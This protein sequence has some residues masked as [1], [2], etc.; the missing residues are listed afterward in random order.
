[1]TVSQQPP[2]R[3]HND[4]DKVWNEPE[5]KQ[6][7]DFNQTP[8]YINLPNLTKESPKRESSEDLPRSPSTDPGSPNM[9]FDDD[10]RN[11]L[12][13][14]STSSLPKGSPSISLKSL[15]PKALKKNNKT[16]QQEFQSNEA[17]L[18]HRRSLQGSL[19]IKD[20]MKT[21]NGGPRYVKSDDVKRISQNSDRQSQ[22]GE[23]HEDKPE[24]IGAF[25][26]TSEFLPFHGYGESIQANDPD[27][28]KLIKKIIE[29]SN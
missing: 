4:Y 9:G 2:Q 19:S 23:G 28:A 29:E 13:P 15:T 6:S 21:D 25:R 11:L 12:R 1:V 22:H 27:E 17:L 3:T 14:Q 8:G 18:Q 20:V 24:Y 7:P 26:P 10:E 5:V 16:K